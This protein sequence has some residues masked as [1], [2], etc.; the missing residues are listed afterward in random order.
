[1]ANP[2]FL[3][4]PGADGKPIRFSLG[5]KTVV[6]RSA[7][8]DL[9]IDHPSVSRKH[10]E[11]VCD[12]LGR[13][14]MRDLESRNG[15]SVNGAA[16]RQPVALHDG[17][18]ISLG[19]IAL[20]FASPTSHAPPPVRDSEDAPGM[21]LSALR[22]MPLSRLA[23]EQVAAI[24]NF[25]RSLEGIV[26]STQ[27]LRRLL[28][29]AVQTEVGGW[30]SY[31]LRVTRR[32]EQLQL[33]N[34]IPPHSSPYGASREPH[35]SKTVLNSVF[36]RGEPMVA[37]KLAKVQ[38]FQA[39]LT[40][41]PD[42]D[43]FS[44]IACPLLREDQQMDVLYVILPP[45]LAGMEWLMLI[46]LA[47]EQYRHSIA[48]AEARSAAAAQAAHER[49]MALA[50]KIQA[51]TLPR[52]T[53][54]T[55]ID[56]EVRFDPCLA[57]AGDYVDVV[58]RDDSSIIFLIADAA[59]KGMQA[60]LI[61]AGLHAIFHTQGRSA[62]SLSD[63][64]A[65]ADQYLKTFLPDDSFVTLCAVLLDPATGH[66]QCA[67]CGHPPMVIIEADGTLR[68]IEGGDNLPLGLCEDS[69]ATHPFELKPGDRLIGYTD[70]LT[71]LRNPDGGMLGIAPLQ[72]RLKEICTNAPAAGAASLAC[73]VAE[74]LESFRASATAGD[75]RTFFVARRTA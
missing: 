22:Q 40:V 50:R 60:A 42:A 21:T 66:G 14:M 27:R 58:K 34:V 65:A 19:E 46:S 32:E 43:K 33:R 3:D 16:A 51:R 74:F 9:V 4:Y 69:V 52:A 23:S 25:G 61:T 48:A 26:D 41:S 30:W 36:E 64:V 12:E 10:A 11:I 38:A 49:E 62:A 57:V 20:R 29:L 39:E 44:A 5:E 28:E 13:W 54:V 63:V 1:M 6:G 2:A 55:A 18:Q 68:E 45:D 70:G 53:A 59:G 71:E 31:A 15:T 8:A 56:W 37:N 75:D 7:S 24:L 17:D 67:N 47:V 35:V 72:A 73:T